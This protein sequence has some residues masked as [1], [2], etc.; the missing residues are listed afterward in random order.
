MKN[1][2]NRI[3]RI[4]EKNTIKDPLGV[5]LINGD[6]TIGCLDKKY[7]V[8]MLDKIT[9]RYDKCVIFSGENELE[10]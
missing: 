9:G 8:D 10:D 7:S 4:E 6:G 3:R 1:I 2:E 5:I